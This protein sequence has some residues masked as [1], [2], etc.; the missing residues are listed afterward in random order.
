MIVGLP[1]PSF[2]AAFFAERAAGF[3]ADFPAGFFAAGFLAGFFAAG[4]PAGFFAC[5]FT[6]SSSGRLG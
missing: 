2:A 6:A 5:F 3:L 1:A 4:F